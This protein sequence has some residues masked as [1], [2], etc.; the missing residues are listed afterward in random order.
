MNKL[1]SE[2][3]LFVVMFGALST[4]PAKSDGILKSGFGDSV[5][6]YTKYRGPTGSDI[7]GPMNR[8]YEKT[9]VEI[10]GCTYK[11]GVCDPQ[12]IWV[13]RKYGTTAG[14]PFTNAFNPG[15]GGSD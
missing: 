2:G 9:G 3:I 15:S 4:V 8:G 6:H 14:L 10:K 1:F 7:S 13:L 5:G 12:D 11:D